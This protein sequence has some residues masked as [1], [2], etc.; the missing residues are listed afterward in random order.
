MKQLLVNYFKN[1]TGWSSSRKIV[2]F[3]VDDYGNIRLSSEKARLN[4]IKSGI[5][6]KGRFDTYDALDTKED[7][8]QLFVVLQSV[9]DS[10]SNSAVFTTYA[11]PCNINYAETKENGKFIP[12]NLEATYTR[13]S[14]IDP[15][16]Y[17]DTIQL[18]HEGITKNL[19]RPQFHGR[20][21]FN[22]N[23]FNALLADREPTLLANLDNQSLAGLPDHK[24]F[25]T[26]KYS[27]A[28]AF[29]KEQEI[30]LHKQIIEDGLNQFEKVYGLRPKTFTPPAMKLH[31]SLFGFLEEKGIIAIDKSRVENRHLGYGKY[32]K[33]RNTT[34]VQ[35]G[36]RH[37]T[38][39]RNCMFEPNSS[40]IDWVNFTFNQIKA[41][42][43]LKKPAIISS[44]RVNFCG[45]IDPTNRKKGLSTLESLLKKV[46]KTWPDVEFMAIDD[47]ATEILN[48]KKLK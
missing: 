6:L 2:C 5:G 11:V 38:I 18:V 47:L 34:G 7:Y 25:I 39:V 17:K 16:E 20:E 14:D 10:K 43:I 45:H 46:V 21:H 15:A 44:H 23:L 32:I 29:W 27:E 31:P 40:D 22:V 3:A 24:D 28:F 26:V 48:S 42:F 41:A 12:E 8:K 4:L 35:A 33:E 19:I 30:E 9:K 36:Q 1:I 13:L 37:V